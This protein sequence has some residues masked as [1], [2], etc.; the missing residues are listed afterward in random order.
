LREANLLAACSLAV[1]DRVQAAAE[2]AAGH[3]ASAP[4]ALVA[5]DGPGAGASID[6]LRRGIGLTHSGAVRL[7]DRLAA[8]GLVER[9]VGADQRSVSLVLTPA[10]RRLARRVRSAREAEVETILA[11]LR[12]DRRR[13]LTD[14]LEQLLAGLAAGGAPRSSV[15]RLCDRQECT[16]CPFERA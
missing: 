16:D 7:V 15:C 4:A 2:G 6:V 12:P 10:G 1:A 11:E 8:A 3:G 9:R 5:L 13:L 14:I